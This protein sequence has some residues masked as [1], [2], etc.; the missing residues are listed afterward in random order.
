M[1]ALENILMLT[2]AGSVALALTA[3][4]P[5]G[6]KA[7]VE[8]IQDFMESPAD[9]P[10]KYDDFFKDAHTAARVPP[11]HTVPV[12]FK[13][14]KWGTDV[15]TAAKENKNP[16]AGD[17]SKDVMMTGQKSYETHCM[18][19]HGMNGKGDGPVA[20][21]MPLKPPPLVSDKIKGWT[22]GNIYHVITM[23]QGV[24]GPYSVHVPQSFRWQLVNYIRHLQKVDSE[25]ATAA[26]K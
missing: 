23:G 16:L 11:D 9:K 14:Y 6:G 17:V 13:P 3:C 10:Q 8:I 1:R 7:N 25:S 22:D 20:V 4:G 26:K 24:M 15:A 12:G 5:S 18:V 21:K 19:C 2:V